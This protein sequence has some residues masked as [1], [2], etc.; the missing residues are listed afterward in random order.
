MPRCKHVS[1]WPLKMGPGAPVCASHSRTVLS[2]LPEAIWWPL[3]EYTSTL[4]NHTRYGHSRWDQVHRFVR[5]TAALSCPDFPR[6]S[7]GRLANI[8]RCV[9]KVVWPLK[10]GPG[11]PVCASHSRTVL[12]HCPR[13]SGGRLANMSRCKPSRYGRS[14]WDQVHRFAHPTAALSCPHFLRRSGG[15]LVNIPRW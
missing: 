15:R 5:P 11:A 3:G 7:G 4:V 14:R 13:R 12:S 1:V 8:S 6:R 9:T 2:S 10:M